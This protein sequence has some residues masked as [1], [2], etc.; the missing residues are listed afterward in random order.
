MGAEP[1][2]GMT[3]FYEELDA[4]TLP[5]LGFRVR[6]EYI[7]WGQE[8]IRLSR[9]IENGEADILCAGEWSNYFHYAQKNA[10]VDLEP[11]LDSVPALKKAMTDFLGERYLSIVGT[12]GSLYGIPEMASSPVIYGVLYR[13]D[14]RLAWGLEEIADFDVL[15][16]YLYRA[17]E[18]G[19]DAPVRDEGIMYHLWNLIAGNRYLFVPNLGNHF[20]VPLDDLSRVSLWYET[21]EYRQCLE[22]LQRWYRDG[23][24]RHDILVGT[25]RENHVDMAENRMCVDMAGHL[26][27]VD[28]YYIPVIMEDHPDYQLRFLPC[29]MLSE[30]FPYF[31]ETLSST[32]VCISSS[33]ESIEEAMKFIEKVFTDECYAHLVRY[34]VEGLNYVQRSGSF[35]YEG[36][37][38]GNILRSWTG[39]KNDRFRLNIL[40]PY[41]SWN[42]SLQQARD[43]VNGQME[44]QDTRAPFNGFILISF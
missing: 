14:L 17:T 34:G 19:Y 40:S 5:E 23:I 11:L 36:I 16:K 30:G 35:S 7:P 25:Q 26:D 32:M 27:P 42:E 44:Q 38:S 31:R 37:D 21:P 22:I 13:E 2:C 28:R 6:V 10:F 9:V 4:L 39:M 18:E 33:S 20:V 41:A 1:A 29:G 8:S 3:R 24:V 12:N 15:E 43:F